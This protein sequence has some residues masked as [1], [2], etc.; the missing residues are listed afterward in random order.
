MAT[1]A[2]RFYGQVKKLTETQKNALTSSMKDLDLS[3]NKDEV[4]FFYEG[5]YIDYDSYLEEIEKII[6]ENNTG[7]IDVIDLLDWRMARYVIANG[8]MKKKDIPL[9]EVLERYNY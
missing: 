6:T 8:Q 4:E 3:I 9:N 1:N 7:Q 5:P 2:L